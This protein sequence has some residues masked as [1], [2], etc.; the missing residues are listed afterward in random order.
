MNKDIDANLILASR[1]PRRLQIMK[2]LG[3]KFKIDHPDIVESRPSGKVSPPEY[4]KG[5]ALEK[6]ADVRIRQ[7]SSIVIGADTLVCIGG[8]ILGKP[9]SPQD[10]KRMLL[11]LR[12]QVNEV[13][14]GVAISD[15]KSGEIITSSMSSYVLMRNYSDSDLDSFVASGNAFD[16]AGAYSVQDR[17]FRPASI[18]NGCSLNVVGFPACLVVELLQIIGVT[19]NP[20][21]SRRPKSQCIGCRV[22]TVNGNR[23]AK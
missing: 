19:T 21:Y 20:N 9:S 11:K 12:G 16:K 6:A 3:L 23:E 14:T 18:V 4:A 22:L 10:A 8:Q 7:D 2:M 17:S 13:I 5:L 1:S 15:G